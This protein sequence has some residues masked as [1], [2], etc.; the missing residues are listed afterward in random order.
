[1]ITRRVFRDEEG[2][3]S[4]NKVRC[5][6]LDVKEFFMDTGV[7]A[8]TYSLVEQG[9]IANLMEAKPEERRQ[10]IEEAAGITKYK[11]R[12]EAAV[13]KMESTKQNMLRLNDIL[14]EVKSQLNSVSRQAKRAERYKLLKKDLR[15]I[16]LTLA[17]QAF[18]EMLEKKTACSGALTNP[19]PPPRTSARSSRCWRPVSRSSGPRS[20][21]TIRTSSNSRSGSIRQKMK[22]ASGSR[23]S[24]MPGAVSTIWPPSRN[25]AQSS[26]S[27]CAPARGKRRGSWRRCGCS[28]PS[29]TA[30]SFPAGR[31]LPCGRASSTS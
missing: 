7:G 17:V 28:R 26:W 27:R 14:R 23:E 15:E 31:H 19:R 11:S 12:K 29:R 1:M 22:S 13:R 3:Y 20:P 2:E 4:I 8:R 25:G 10:Y 30:G 5:R 24:S 9:S 18:T 6:L 21:R 16:E